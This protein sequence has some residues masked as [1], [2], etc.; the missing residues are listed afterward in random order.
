MSLYGFCSMRLACG[1]SNGAVAR[2][3]QAVDVFVRELLTRGRLPSSAANPIKAKQ[4]EF[5]CQT[6]DNH[7]A[8]GPWR[9]CCP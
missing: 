6:R 4:T 1:A 3:E 9:R 2:D 7:R 8:S 5:L